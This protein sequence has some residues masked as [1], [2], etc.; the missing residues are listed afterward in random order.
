MDIL[1][2]EDDQSTRRGIELFLKSQGHAVTTVD[3][4]SDGLDHCLDNPPDL[5]ISDVKMPR[6]TGLDMLT[7][8]RSRQIQVPV[9]MIT[10][11]AT[12]ED[13]VEA[14]QQGADDYMTKPLN[15]E[16]LKIKIQQLQDRAHLKE[17]NTALRKR[18]N[19]WEH[20]DLI[21]CSRAMDAVRAKIDQVAA[22]PDIPVMIYGESGTGKELAARTIHNRSDRENLPFVPVNCAAFPEDLLESELF[23]YKKGAF[24]GAMKD[25]DG[26]FRAADGGTLFLDEVSEMSPKMQ[27][28]LLR[29]LQ[30]GV[31]QPLG[32]TSPAAV[33][34]R[35]LGASNRDL[36]KMISEGSFREDLFYRL[37]VMEV[38]LPALRE[39]REDIPLLVTHFLQ[40][41]AKSP[42]HFASETL[43]E[44]QKYDWPGNVRE[45][46]NVIRRAIVMRSG[47]EIN[48][49]DLPDEVVPKTGFTTPW[50]QAMNR[51]DF[52]SALSDLTTAFERD[53]L[54]QHLKAHNWN[55]S[56]TAGSIGVSRAALHK[57]IKLLGLT[58]PR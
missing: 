15:L 51:N 26:F 38:L 56:K 31:F 45:L 39:R 12:V 23:G 6:M 44:M 43:Q 1:I 19:K 50:N 35:I 14:M 20:P 49:K 53:F 2:A 10:A 21:G 58:P 13:A 36:K 54:M 9:I 33:N 41:Y 48:V 32:S 30:E 4:G 11:F 42:V 22:D 37:N 57:K 18:L 52:K 40:K 8:I 3:N 28:K 25:K 17:E 46:E 27:A 24:T 55:I 34:V 47:E 5:I 29:V 16:A 7:R